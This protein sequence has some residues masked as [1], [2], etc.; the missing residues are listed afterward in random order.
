[1]E[2][3]NTGL[4]NPVREHKDGTH[5][6][7]NSQLHITIDNI[8]RCAVDLLLQKRERRERNGRTENFEREIEVQKK[9]VIFS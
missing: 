2:F 8:N 4:S 3:L 5:N 1:M 6:L 9:P 7:K